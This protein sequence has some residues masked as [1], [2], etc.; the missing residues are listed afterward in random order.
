MLLAG[1]C[2][3]VR[4]GRGEAHADDEHE[5]GVALGFRIMAVAARGRQL[6]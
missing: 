2:V 6:Q 1:V 5:G 3:V 4:L